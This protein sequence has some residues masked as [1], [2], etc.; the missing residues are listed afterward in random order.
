M[1]QVLLSP[2]E[3]KTISFPSGYY[4]LKIAEGA[5]WINDKEAF[6]P[7]GEYSSTSVY[8]FEAGSTYRIGS[9]NR[10]DFHG[11]DQSGF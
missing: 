2:N 5:N 7:D 9:G 10:G 8:G 11:T 6:G 1:Q 4:T 3:S